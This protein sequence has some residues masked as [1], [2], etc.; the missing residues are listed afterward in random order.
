MTN[1]PQLIWHDPV[2]QQQ[3]H[4]WIHEQ[5]QQNSLQPIGEIEQNHAYAWSTVMR[6]PTDQ[7]TLFFK[8]TAPE[9][10]YE[11]ALTQKLAQWFP[12]AMPELVAADP[13]RG[14]ML[15]GDGG[16]QLRASIRPTQDIKPW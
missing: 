9:T 14:W 1:Q 16:E 7:G 10:I 11:I 8:A 15:R 2:W 4:N 5:A 13:T 12:D 6:V 3:A